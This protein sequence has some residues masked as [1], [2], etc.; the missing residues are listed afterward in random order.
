MNSMEKDAFLHEMKRLGSITF[1]HRRYLLE[2]RPT[3]LTDFQTGKRTRFKNIE[4]AYDNAIIGKISLR[5]LVADAST[6]RELWYP[7]EKMGKGITIDDSDIQI[8]S[9][10]D[11]KKLWPDAYSDD[12]E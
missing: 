9:I 1:E 10:E 5:Q 3:C 8:V 6:V 7:E 12:E 4:E 2:Y 11:A